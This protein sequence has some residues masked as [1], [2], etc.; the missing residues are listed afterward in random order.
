ML[1]FPYL[2]GLLTTI[3]L[4]ACSAHAQQSGQMVTE[5]PPG[6]TN[7]DSKAIHAAFADKVLF[8]TYANGI[9]VRYE[10]KGEFL[11]LN[12][13]NGASDTVKWRI[14]DAKLC[15][16]SISGRFPNGCSESRLEGETIWVK[17][18]ANGEVVK[19]AKD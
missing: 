14:D 10:F 3:L 19:L 13:S 4:V 12:V 17:R 5:F 2:K 1:N 15:T 9:K 11:Y 6:A 18:F 8:T 7:N 16:E